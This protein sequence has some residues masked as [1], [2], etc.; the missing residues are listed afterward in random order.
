MALARKR[1]S[2]HAAAPHA[3]CSRT[4]NIHLYNL[5]LCDRGK[6]RTGFWNLSPSPPPPPRF[7]SY[8]YQLWF[9]PGMAKVDKLSRILYIC[10]LKLEIDLRFLHDDIELFNTRES[11]L[12][13]PPPLGGPCVCYKS[14]YS[15]ATIACV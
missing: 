7:L 13:A 11:M 3:A 12:F 9:C 8:G 15:A 14:R 1:H 10:L 4:R 2:A 6:I 5:N